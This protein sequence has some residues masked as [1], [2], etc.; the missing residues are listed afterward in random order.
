MPI[1]IAGKNYT[2]LAKNLQHFVENIRFFCAD[3]GAVAR[4]Y[5][6]TILAKSPTKKFM[7]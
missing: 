1:G 7:F 3:F 5:F 4:G 6:I 2:Y